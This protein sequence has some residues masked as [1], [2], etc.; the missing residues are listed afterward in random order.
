MEKNLNTDEMYKNDE[1]LKILCSKLDE[2]KDKR[3]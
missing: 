1:I 2:L 3:R